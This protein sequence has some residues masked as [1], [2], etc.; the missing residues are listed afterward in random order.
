MDRSAAE[1]ELRSE[2]NAQLTRW[3]HYCLSEL[4][5]GDDAFPKGLYL[6][7]V[8]GGLWLRGYVCDPAYR[9]PGD[10]L[11]ALEIYRT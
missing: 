8:D 7:K 11:F 6:R 1:S 9:F 10:A 2:R 3:G 4:L 5:E